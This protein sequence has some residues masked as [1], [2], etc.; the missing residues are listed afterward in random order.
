MNNELLELLAEINRLRPHYQS[1]TATDAGR[2][3]MLDHFEKVIQAKLSQEK[4]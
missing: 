2:R 1:M 3:Q 4:V